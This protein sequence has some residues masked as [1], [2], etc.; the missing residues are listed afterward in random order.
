MLRDGSALTGLQPGQN[1]LERG[2]A[3]L[4]VG[5]VFAIWIIS[6]ATSLLGRATA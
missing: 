4:V 1:E 6:L 3:G 2:L 5:I